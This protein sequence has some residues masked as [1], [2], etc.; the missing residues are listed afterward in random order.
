MVTLSDC[1]R[2]ERQVFRVLCTHAGKPLS[3]RAIAQIVNATPQGVAKALKL[4][5]KERLA[6]AEPDVRLRLIRVRLHEQATDHKR[7]ENL[8]QLAESGLIDHLRTRNPTATIVLFGSYSRGEDT[9]ESDIDIALIG[10]SRETNITS[11]EPKLLR[12]IS[13][14]RYDSFEHIHPLLRENLCNGIILAGSMRWSG[15]SKSIR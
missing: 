5:I 11:F 10:P 9:I 2:L 1:S 13:L 14:N 6:T 3:Q 4:L 8:L 15:P 7:S 12:K